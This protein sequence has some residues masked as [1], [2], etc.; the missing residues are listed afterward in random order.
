[1]E[2]QALLLYSLR[3]PHLPCV[4]KCL[5]RPALEQVDH[6]F[7]VLGEIQSEF[8][9]DR[10]TVLLLN[11]L[12]H[13]LKT[14]H[15][16]PAAD[17]TLAG[18]EHHGAILTA[19]AESLLD[20]VV[21]FK[22]RILEIPRQLRLNILQLEFLQAFLFFINDFQLSLRELVLFRDC[23]KICGFRSVKIDQ[24]RVRSLRPVNSRCSQ[25]HDKTQHSG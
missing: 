24:P 11:S 6:V 9:I 5:K 3:K 25:P 16:I 8:N 20:F 15:H 17:K 7:P 12:H 1:M 4:L 22:K 18:N 19:L 13:L 23:D 14:L 2:Q 10:L 21:M